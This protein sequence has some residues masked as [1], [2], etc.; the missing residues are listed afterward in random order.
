MRRTCQ[1]RGRPPLL[2]CGGEHEP[3]ASRKQRRSIFQRVCTAVLRVDLLLLESELQKTSGIYKCTSFTTLFFCFNKLS[4]NQSNSTITI[5]IITT[6]IKD[7][8]D[9]GGAY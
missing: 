9:V 5:V 2:V 8:K 7:R 1:T 6:V 3:A 4:V